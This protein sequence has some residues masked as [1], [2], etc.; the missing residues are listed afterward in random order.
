MSWFSGILPDQLVKAIGWTLFHSLWQGAVIVLLFMVLYYKFR[1]HKAE[2]RYIISVAALLV[3]FL[4]VSV[5]FVVSFSAAGTPG[6]EFA[7]NHPVRESV[8]PSLLETSVWQSPE[9]NDTGRVQ[10]IMQ[11]I[12]EKFSIIVNLWVMGLLLI[13][14]RL[15]GSS[16]MAFR[17]KRTN[18]ARVPDHILERFTHLIERLNVSGRIKLMGSKLAKN[19]MVIGYLK[20]VVLVPASI[21]S[22]IS[23]EQ[24]DAILVHELAHIKRH[25]FLVNVFQNILELFMF[26]HPVVWFLNHQIRKERENCC[27]DMAVAYGGPLNYARALAQVHEIRF[28]PKLVVAL[29]TKKYHLLNRVVRILKPKKMKT[30]VIDKLITGVILMAAV[31]VVLISTGATYSQHKEAVSEQNHTSYINSIAPIEVADPQPEL[32]FNAMDETVIEPNHEKIVPDNQETDSTL[33]IKDNVI[34]RTIDD[35]GKVRK[36]KLVVK[37]GEVT[38]LYVDGKKIP[39]EKHGKYQAEIDETLEEVISMKHS[40]AEARFE[41]DE[42]DWEELKQDLQK[43]LQKVM[44]INIDEIRAELQEIELPEIDWEEIQKEIQMSI[45]SAME[46]LKEIDFDEIR[47]EL[48]QSL[49]DMHIKDEDVRREKEKEI[50]EEI[51]RAMKEVEEEK[52]KLDEEMVEMREQMSLEYEAEMAE[53]RQ[54]IEKSIQEL[55]MINEQEI[56]KDIEM[57]MKELEESEIDME[58]EKKKIDEMIKEIE[59]LELKDN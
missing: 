11:H 27:D 31:S 53:A 22:H 10:L 41:L 59:K 58:I 25:D 8:I 40:L 44:E 12:T 7:V 20:P 33:K 14:V 55:E 16:V 32:V 50:Q 36:L 29:S 23:C 3:L 37:G 30:N 2:L 49:E 24:L 56:Q 39:K 9:S 21:I 51:E 34:T 15:A 5:T 17:Y 47:K 26:Y 18:L 13:S 46:S 4:A 45:E 57:A 48:E 52:I 28:Y 43:D 35:N 42:I 54:E 6:N 19:P 38:E 1:Q